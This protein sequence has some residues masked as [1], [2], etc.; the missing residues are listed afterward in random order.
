[1]CGPRPQPYVRVQT[2]LTH[3]MDIRFS[4]MCIGL[5]AL[6]LEG[7][8]KLQETITKSKV[9]WIYGE[10]NVASPASADAASGLKQEGHKVTK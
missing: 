7:L 5:S 9:H 10:N 3:A 2:V 6:H 8:Q 4:F 1:M